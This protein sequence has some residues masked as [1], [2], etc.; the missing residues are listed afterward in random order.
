MKTIPITSIRIAPNRQRREFDPAELQELSD[1]ISKR[2]L[3]HPIILRKEVDEF[4]LVAGERRLRAIT[5]IYGLGGSFLHDGLPVAA[6]EIPYTLL[7]DLDPLAVEEAEL[8]ENI[9]RKDLSWQE[10]AAACARIASL[11][12]RQAEVSGVRPP[13]IADIALEIRGSAEGS[14][15]SNTR[16]EI[17]VSR[18]LNNPAIAAAK[19]V[20]EA[21]KILRKE[22]QKEKSRALGESVGRTFTADTHKALHEDSITWMENCAENSFDVI[23]A[24]PP[25][26]MGADEFGDS[27]G[28]A[29]GGHDYKD[30]F[31]TFRRCAI[32]IAYEGFRITKPQAHAYVFCDFDNFH[33]LKTYMTEAGWQVF[34]TPLIWYKKSGQRAPWPEYGPQR[35]YECILYAIKGKRPVLKM[36]PDVLDFPSDDNLGHA[37]QKPVAL[38]K[39]LLSRSVMP[40]DSVLDPFMGSGPIFPA[41][42]ALKARATGIEQ[43]QASYGIAVNRIEQLRA[44]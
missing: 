38:Y 24:D 21:F 10:R 3:L 7:S 22:E 41:A 36:A 26:G 40:G 12:Q 29:A 11:R 39:E 9:H 8:E 32:A 34:R 17:I 43:D 23:L 15:Q 25:Y 1:G 13:T 20:D 2:G 19:T 18:H 30:D 14:N 16:R 37:A 5:D 6:D 4:F 31:V 33:K 27:G 42:H 44:E 35:K 28:L